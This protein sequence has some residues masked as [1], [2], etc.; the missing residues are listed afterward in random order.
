MLGKVSKYEWASTMRVILPIFCALL[1]CSLLLRLEILTGIADFNTTG[2]RIMAGITVSIYILLAVSMAAIV[3]VVLVKRFYTSMFGDEGYLTFTLPCHPDTVMNGKA[4]VAFLWMVLSSLC[5]ILSFLIIGVDSK[6]LSE[7]GEI[8]EDLDE[9]L[10][11]YD[12]SI[13]TMLTWFI[14]LSLVGTL[15]TIYKVIMS[16]AIGQLAN[17]NKVALS[18]VAYIGVGIIQN[19]LS[20]I[21]PKS[22]ALNTMEDILVHNTGASLSGLTPHEV[23]YQVCGYSLFYTVLGLVI[24]Y[25]VSHFIIN[26][27]LNL[28]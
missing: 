11:R 21:L 10:V 24:F 18:V 3:A 12:L 4:L 6:F 16:M 7:I 1:L 26:K 20:F 5:I 19:I 23:F 28:Q 17:R 27:K 25:L 15:N 22:N 14:V 9:V 13:G 8:L 2:A